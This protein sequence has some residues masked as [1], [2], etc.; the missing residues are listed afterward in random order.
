MFN[1]DSFVEFAST[2]INRDLDWISGHNDFNAAE[3]KRIKKK[4]FEAECRTYMDKLKADVEKELEERKEKDKKEI[5]RLRKELDAQ[6][7]ELKIREEALNERTK[8]AEELEKKLSEREHT[9]EEKIKESEDVIAAHTERLEKATARYLAERKLWEQAL[10]DKKKAPANYQ[11]EFSSIGESFRTMNELVIET[12]K[13]LAEARNAV[14]NTFDDGVEEL[15]KLYSEMYFTEDP[16]IEEKADVLAEILIRRFGAEPF[17]PEPDSVYC[18]ELHEK[19]N[20]NDKGD[21]VAF[22]RVRGWKYKN[23]PLLRAIVE[24]KKGDN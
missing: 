2:L 16:H 10:K 14:C 11:A 19:L 12:R 5:K 21:T 15:C 7:F 9:I 20:Y 3:E 6:R 8:V 4:E 23:R 22:C 13:E 1:Y 18:S 17:E 24:T